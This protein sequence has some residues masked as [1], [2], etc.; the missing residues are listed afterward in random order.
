[1]PV[2]AGRRRGQAEDVARLA[3]ARHRLEADRRHVVTLIDHEV[4]IVGD[5]VIDLSFAHEALYDG[6]VDDTGRPA[7]A[8]ADPTDLLG[9]LI[10]KA[11]E[12]RD[13]LVEELTA[14]HQ[15]Q[16]GSIDVHL[17]TQHDL[18]GL[19]QRAGDGSVRLSPGRRCK[20]W[21]FV[22]VLHHRQTYTEHAPAPPGFFGQVAHL[23]GGHAPDRRQ[24]PPLVGCGWNSSSRNTLLPDW[25]GLC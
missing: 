11:A 19:R 25:R 14:M 15:N 1:M 20:P 22:L 18:D 24:A 8:A 2:L 7:L 6:D 17:I 3:A 4:S 9:A 21:R 23:D 5:D 10:E 12:P 13:P 16:P